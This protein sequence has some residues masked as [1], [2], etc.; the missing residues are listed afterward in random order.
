MGKM[1]GGVSVGKMGGGVSGED[2]R[3]SEWGR[4]EGE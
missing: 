1:G 2:G 4:W 3:G